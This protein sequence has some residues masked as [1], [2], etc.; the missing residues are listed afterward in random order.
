MRSGLAVMEYQEVLDKL[1]VTK[2]VVH[3]GS[4]AAESPYLG[5]NRLCIS[6]HVWAGVLLK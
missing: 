5:S 1:P 2:S 4:F 6:A 3:M